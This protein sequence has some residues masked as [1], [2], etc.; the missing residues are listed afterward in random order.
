MPEEVSSGITPG[1]TLGMRIDQSVNSQQGASRDLSQ[2]IQHLKEALPL[3][4][5]AGDIYPDSST[6]AHFCYAEELVAL[7]PMPRE[8]NMALTGRI[9]GQPTRTEKGKSNTSWQAAVHE[10]A[11]ADGPRLPH[12]SQ[13]LRFLLTH[14]GST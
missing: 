7:V 1:V 2:L 3:L 8:C 13:A 11:M 12:V 6:C 10:A 5:L 14:T 4:Y 9:S